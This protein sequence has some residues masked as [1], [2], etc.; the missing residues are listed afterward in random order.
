[1]YRL[2]VL[3]CLLLTCAIIVGP[4]AAQEAEKIMEVEYEG[5]MLKVTVPELVDVAEEFAVWTQPVRDNGAVRVAIRAGEW[6]LLRAKVGSYSTV[7]G[8]DC[9]VLPNPPSAKPVSSMHDPDDCNRPARFK[10][11]GSC[12]PCFKNGIP[13]RCCYGCLCCPT[14][15]G[16]SCAYCGW[17]ETESYLPPDDPDLTPRRQ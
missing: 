4:V 12:Q 6:T 16:E 14:D 1:M 9:D 13:A 17:W 3:V 11:T 8:L 5:S 7:P 15:N 2:T 10:Q